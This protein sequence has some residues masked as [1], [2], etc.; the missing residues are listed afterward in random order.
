MSARAS[1]TG[2]SRKAIIKRVAKA[3]ETEEG[4]SQLAAA[5][6]QAKVIAASVPGLSVQSKSCTESLGHIP[7]HRIPNT[8]RKAVEAETGLSKWSANRKLAQS[9]SEE[10]IDL[11]APMTVAE[12]ISAVDQI[13]QHRHSLMKGEVES[14]SPQKSKG[15]EYRV[16]YSAPLVFRHAVFAAVSAC[17]SPRTGWRRFGKTRDGTRRCINTRPSTWVGLQT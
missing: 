16:R 6:G 9:R 7:P 3:A 12:Q 5:R 2:I 14:R 10:A 11:G 13:E 17:I 15:A 4:R 8:T 1:L